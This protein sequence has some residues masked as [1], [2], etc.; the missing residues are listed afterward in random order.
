M[1]LELELKKLGLSDKEAKV[2]LALLE[3][4]EGPVQEIAQKAGVNRATT[5]VILDSLMKQ[6][7]V[8]TVEKGKKTYYA[9]ESPRAL[10][11]LFR[12]Q[13]KEI[14]EKEAEFKRVLP[15][16]EGI[17]NLSGEKPRVRYFEGKEGLRAM[18]E[19]FLK[20]GVS[21]LLAVF[22]SDDF[23]NIFT[24]EE[25]KRYT[26]RREALGISVR[27]IYTRSDGPVPNPPPG[28]RI[29]VPKEKFPFSS[30][31]TI[32]GNRI[33]MATLRGKLIGVI[34]DSEEIAGTLRLVFE[35]AWRGG[36]SVQ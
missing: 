15:E 28:K 5:Y 27:S 12:L 23:R 20:S 30:D 26:D 34:I 14:Q 2:Y 32:Y 31:I 17:H 8:S 4:G 18:Q 13:E 36:E 7:M 1:A 6:G 19:D 16:L 22:S 21:E 9:A 3:I 25:R 24:E 35:L 10:L 33:A 29:F 11:R